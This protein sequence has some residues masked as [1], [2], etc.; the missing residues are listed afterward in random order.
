[1][2][3]YRFTNKQTGEFTGMLKATVK[4]SQEIAD[5]LLRGSLNTEWGIRLKVEKNR[6]NHEVALTVARL[7]T[8]PKIAKAINYASSVDTQDI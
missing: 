1:M 2:D 7:V 3:M 4:G 5:C 6:E 8:W